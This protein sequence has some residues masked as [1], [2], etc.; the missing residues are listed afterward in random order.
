M[1]HNGLFTD[2]NNSVGKVPP[3]CKPLH[4]AVLGQSESIVEQLLDSGASADVLSENSHLMALQLAG[5]RHEDI[6]RLLVDRGATIE[7]EH[8]GKRTALHFE[9]K[10]SHEATARLLLDRGANVK[11]QYSGNRTALHVAAEGGHDPYGT[12]NMYN[13]YL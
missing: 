11:A 8:K 9:V 4:L 7:A 12:S 10:S 13:S 6:A 3:G 2:L 5:E 1:C